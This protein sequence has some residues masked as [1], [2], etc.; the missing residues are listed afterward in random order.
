MIE[1]SQ[2]SSVQRAG[3]MIMF[4]TM[5]DDKF[6]STQTG[7]P[8]LLETEEERNKFIAAVKSPVARD[9]LNFDVRRSFIDLLSFIKGRD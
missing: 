9:L 1:G 7:F 3:D 2:R 6:R 8:R 5:N 4:N